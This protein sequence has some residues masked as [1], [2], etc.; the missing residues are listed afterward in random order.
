MSVTV[1]SGQ[2]VLDLA[3]QTAGSVESAFQLAVTN[4]ISVT[5][6]LAVGREV[7]SVSAANKPVY[8]YYQNHQLK[9]S[10]G[11]ITEQMIIRRGIG[12]MGV[13]VDF[14]VTAAN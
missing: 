12:S 2:S 13:G 4:G 14:V 7:I 1:L 5:D 11:T 10:T 3:V 6:S 9:P 8:D